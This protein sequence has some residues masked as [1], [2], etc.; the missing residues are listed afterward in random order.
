M[1]TLAGLAQVRPRDLRIELS[2]ELAVAR[3]LRQDRPLATYIGWT[4]QGNLGDEILLEAHERL[5]PGLSLVPFQR[6]E[7]AARIA[8]R[9]SR[10]PGFTAGFLGG[11]TLINQSVTW[12][13]RTQQLLDRGLPVGCLGAGVQTP[14]FQHDFERTQLADWAPVLRELEFLGVRGPRSAEILAD[15]GIDVEITG[16]PALAL[17]PEEAPTPAPVP[18]TIGFNLGV[19]GKTLMYGSPQR[20]LDAAVETIRQLTAAG[21]QVRLLPVTAADLP[22]NEQVLER[23]GHPECV[24]HRCWGSY[25]AYAAATRSCEVFVGQKLHATVIAITQRVP[26]VMLSYQ[27]KCD[28]FMASIGQRDAVLR[29]DEFTAERA[30]LVI[31]ELRWSGELMANELDAAVRWFRK[32]QHEL[33]AE[34]APRLG[35]APGVEPAGSG[36]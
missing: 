35:S 29:T 15:A 10:G 16:D 9:R 1:P 34:L 2:N 31:E 17:A 18:G 12:L 8:A 36:A 3:A 6:L 19:S 30:T 4:G 24:L 5:F 23:V 13:K 20:F 32:R 7:V 25:A 28:D 21:H 22:S 14:E 33:A 27:P 11:G 26:S